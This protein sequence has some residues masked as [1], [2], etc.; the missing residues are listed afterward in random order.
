MSF[1]FNNDT[2]TG[3]EPLCASCVWG[4]LI[5]SKGI[6]VCDLDLYGHKEVGICN[7]YQERTK[8]NG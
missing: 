1:P 4:H 3:G 8:N 6:F 2:N 7:K 5:H